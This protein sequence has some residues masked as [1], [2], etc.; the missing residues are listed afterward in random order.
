VGRAFPHAPA[1]A[2]GWLLLAQHSLNAGGGRT[3]G[4][5]HI[6]TEDGCLVASFA[7]ENLV[8][9]FRDEPAAR[10]HSTMTL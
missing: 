3:Y 9:A 8:R 2:T 5:G 6:F 7:Q 10:G 4:S 1:E